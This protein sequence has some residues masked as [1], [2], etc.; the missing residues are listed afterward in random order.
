M[1]AMTRH[2]ACPKFSK[3]RSDRSFIDFSL[4]HKLELKDSCMV[5]RKIF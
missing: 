2:L 1:W 5:K 4:H 3:L